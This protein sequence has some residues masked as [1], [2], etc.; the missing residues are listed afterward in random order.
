MSFS[1]LK[2][3]EGCNEL[4]SG[5]YISRKLNFDKK[6]IL[7]KIELVK[8]K[9]TSGVNLSNAGGYQ[10]QPYLSQYPEFSDLKKSIE[11]LFNEATGRKIVLTE[12]WA[13]VNPKGTYNNKHDHSGTAQEMFSMFS[14]VLY[15]KVPKGESG[16]LMFYNPFS[17][18]I[19]YTY[20][21]L[22][23]DILFFPNYMAH[24]VTPNF[25]D[26]ERVSIAFNGDLL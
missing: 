7:E 26:E 10:T 5:F 18:N 22:E 20:N 6:D 23:D 24:S 2:N 12:M 1:F 3:I 11:L 21:P 17:E 14:G 9:D 13:N 19:A 16:S 15:I 8:I 25:T 4:F